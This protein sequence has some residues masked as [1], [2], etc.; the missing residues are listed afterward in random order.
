MIKFSDYLNE[1]NLKKVKII[2]NGKKVIVKKCLDSDGNLAHGYK[3]ENNKCVKM[4]SSEKLTRS[5]A[6]KKNQRK[7][8]SKQSQINKKRQKSLNKRNW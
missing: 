2:K 1:V 6:A 8:K 4:S 3:K 7:L 5:K